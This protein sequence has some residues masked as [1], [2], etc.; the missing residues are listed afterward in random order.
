MQIVSNEMP[1]PDPWEN[2]K[3]I[4]NLSSAK[5]SQRVVKVKET[6]RKRKLSF[7]PSSYNIYKRHR[8]P[9][10]VFNTVRQIFTPRGKLNAI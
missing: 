2:K 9:I 6:I 5:Y 1:N 4:I 3:N 10:G 7:A 8:L